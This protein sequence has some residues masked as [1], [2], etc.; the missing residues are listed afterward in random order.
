MYIVL[1]L[2][3]IVGCL[4]LQ[5]CVD[6]FTQEVA[7]DEQ[8]DSFAF[9]KNHSHWPKRDVQGNNAAWRNLFLVIVPVKDLLAIGA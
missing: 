1:T 7:S 8:R 9:R 6:R 3:L 4:K 2:V 5:H